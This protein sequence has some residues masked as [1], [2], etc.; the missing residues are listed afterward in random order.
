[1]VI[2]CIFLPSEAFIL[3]KNASFPLQTYSW[4]AIHGPEW[5]TI[6]EEPS[7]GTVIFDRWIRIAAGFA[8]FLAFG[9]GAEATSAYRRWLLKFG[10]ARIFPSLNRPRVPR[11]NFNSSTDTSGKE[12]YA[13]RAKLWAR[14]VSVD[15]SPSRIILT[16]RKSMWKLRL[17]KFLD[18]QTREVLPRHTVITHGTASKSTP[19]SSGNTFPTSPQWISWPI[20]HSTPNLH[21]LAIEAEKS[22]AS[23]TYQNSIPIKDCPAK[24]VHIPSHPSL[25]TF[26]KNYQPLLSSS[27]FKSADQALQSVIQQPKPTLQHEE[28]Q[29]PPQAYNA[30]HAPSYNTPAQATDR[31]S[32]WKN[33]LY[34]K[35]LTEILPIPSQK[36]NIHR[37]APPSRTIIPPPQDL[38]T[39]LSPS[40]PPTPILNNHRPETESRLPHHNF[41]L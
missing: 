16:F 22:V 41:T 14:K 9:L 25:R 28:E 11:Q 39:C 18:R 12:S 24:Q 7:F 35:S 20:L 3:H 4:A 17:S 40:L 13:S 32:P 29:C 23:A 33:N 10:F 21:Y 26:I 37:I 34:T 36:Q 5:E 19:E 6:I 27:P 30:L 2:L 38:T 31:H 8:I 15:S 1:M